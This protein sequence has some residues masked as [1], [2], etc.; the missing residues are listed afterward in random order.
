MFA[1]RS[2]VFGDQ[3][4][5]RDERRGDRGDRRADQTSPRPPPRS[6]RF[7]WNWTSPDS[8]DYTISKFGTAL[9]TTPG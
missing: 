1:L 3:P 4:P 8:A 7:L 6:N 2:H 5:T 9:D